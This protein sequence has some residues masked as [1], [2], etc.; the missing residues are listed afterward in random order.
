MKGRNVE[1]NLEPPGGPSK[2]CPRAWLRFAVPRLPRPMVFTNGV[3]DLVHAGHVEYLAAARCEGNSLV[4]GINSDASV[5]RLGK[6]PER[7][8][9]NER[10]RAS[11]VAALESVSLVVIFDEDTPMALLQELRPDVYVKGGDYEMAS[12]AEAALVRQWGGRAVTAPYRDGC[13][14]TALVRRMQQVKRVQE[15]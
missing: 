5:R 11:V 15:A 6:G 3:F 12:L 9:N 13:S 8:L 1:E 14:T 2:L 7:P 10:D 4:V